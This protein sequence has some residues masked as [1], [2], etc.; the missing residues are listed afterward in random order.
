M[1]NLHFSLPENMHNFRFIF[2]IIA[3]GSLLGLSYGKD[4]DKE[5]EHKATSRKFSES[6]KWLNNAI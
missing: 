6:I 1:R 2:N 3:S 4:V 5:V